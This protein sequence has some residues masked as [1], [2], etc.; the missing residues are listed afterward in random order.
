MPPIFEVVN[1][2]ITV[3]PAVLSYR[4][5]RPESLNKQSVINSC[6]EN[7]KRL[8]EQSFGTNFIKT[9]RPMK[10]QIRKNLDDYVKFMKKHSKKVIDKGRN[11]GDRKILH[12]FIVL[13][14]LLILLI[15]ISTKIMN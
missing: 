15:L 12:Y 10:C 13:H 1:A 3:E 5:G 4:K 6:A 8:W 7:L 9:I 2:I 11:C 14:L